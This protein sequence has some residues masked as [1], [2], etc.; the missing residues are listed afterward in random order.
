MITKIE[1]THD[2][3]WKE[4]HNKL[5][6]IWGTTCP[7]PPISFLFNQLQHGCW[8]SFLGFKS[9]SIP[10]L[11]EVPKCIH[12]HNHFCSSLVL[13]ADFCSDWIHQSSMVA[14]SAGFV[15]KSCVEDWTSSHTLCAKGHCRQ[16]WWQISGANPQS[17]HKGL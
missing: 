2:T 6:Y 4:I 16:M 5:R 17:E 8:L 7:K 12:D 9:S 11:P 14:S 1:K 3:I 13:F 15:T 10:L